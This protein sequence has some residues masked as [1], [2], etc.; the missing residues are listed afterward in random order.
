LKR[1]KRICEI[2]EPLPEGWHGSVPSAL[3]QVR[4]RPPKGGRAGC[5]RR[6]VPHTSKNTPPSKREGEGV[7]KCAWQALPPKPPFPDPPHSPGGGG[8]SGGGRGRLCDGKKLF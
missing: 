4:G 1:R 5:R 7:R 3:S 6:E 2:C 8:E